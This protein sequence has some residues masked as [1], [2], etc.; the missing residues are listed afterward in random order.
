MC[1][2]PRPDALFRTSRSFHRASARAHAAPR[3]LESATARLSAGLAGS[4]ATALEHL[5]GDDELVARGW[6]LLTRD[7]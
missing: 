3:A 7:A 1:L 2:D 4:A 5:A 6:V